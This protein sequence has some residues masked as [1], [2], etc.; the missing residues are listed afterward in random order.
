MTD[1]I[2][3]IVDGAAVAAA[4]IPRKRKGTGKEYME[5]AKYVRQH[6]FDD[7]S[8]KNFGLV[9]RYG[10][11]VATGNANKGLCLMGPVGVGLVS[12]CGFVVGHFEL[13]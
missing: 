9:T 13:S 5:Y 1:R 4:A 8:A 7:R 3:D 12:L 11:A 6:G 10:W 2:G